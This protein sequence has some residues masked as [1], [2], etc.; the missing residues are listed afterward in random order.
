MRRTSNDCTGRE[1]PSPGDDIGRLYSE[2]SKWLNLDWQRYAPQNPL[3][4]CVRVVGESEVVCRELS[5]NGA[6]CFSSDSVEE[7]GD[8]F[9][10]N[11]FATLRSRGFLGTSA[12]LIAGN[13][14]FK[15]R[16]LRRA[17]QA[18][19]VPGENQEGRRSKLPHSTFLRGLALP[20]H[21]S[22]AD[23]ILA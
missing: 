13:S 20:C 21:A 7:S 15:L 18:T 16:L 9:L 3:P 6:S 8:G 4:D 22:E 17:G 1:E 19:G 12:I 14:L 23:V 10:G 2:T 5:R 11:L